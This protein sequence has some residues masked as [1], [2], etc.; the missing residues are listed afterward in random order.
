MSGRNVCGRSCI[1]WN[2]T[3]GCSNHG[4]ND[5]CRKCN[6]F[7]SKALRSNIKPGDWKC[8]CSTINF[9]KRMSCYKC[10]KEKTTCSTPTSQVIL[11]KPGDWSCPDEGCKTNNFGNRTNC[12][13]CGKER[14]IK[15]NINQ[16]QNQQNEEERKICTI[17]MDNKINTCI[18]TCGHLACCY[19]CGLAMARCPICRTEYNPD[20]DLIKTFEV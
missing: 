10:N 6:L 17:C 4:S 15:K 13:K 1:E 9:A 16:I 18:T 20:K 2:C 7:R 12:F 14:V 19:I 8:D 3:C 11:T 5:K